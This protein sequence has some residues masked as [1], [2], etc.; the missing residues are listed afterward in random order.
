[1]Q[2][3]LDKLHSVWEMGEQV[4]NT[5]QKLQN[6][7]FFPFV[8][9]SACTKGSMLE[10]HTEQVSRELWGKTCAAVGAWNTILGKPRQQAKG[11]GLDQEPAQG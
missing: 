6:S 11:T 1:M 8:L 9:V 4:S 7:L 5:R 2:G 10:Q 3:S